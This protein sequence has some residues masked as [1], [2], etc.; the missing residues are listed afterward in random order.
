MAQQ[1]LLFY[2]DIPQLWLVYLTRLLL[3]EYIFIAVKQSIK[4]SRRTIIKQKLQKSNKEMKRN[5]SGRARTGDLS[6]VLHRDKT[7][8]AFEN[9]REM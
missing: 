6:R 4:K 7:R 5:G 3:L 8:W 1:N 9:T 2:F